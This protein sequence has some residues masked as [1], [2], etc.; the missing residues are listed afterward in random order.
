MDE[1]RIISVDVPPGSRFKGYEDVVVQD[2]VMR[3]HVVRFRRQ[4]WLTP[5]GETIIAPL[6][7]CIAGQFGPELK[8]FVSALPSG[9]NDHAPPGGAAER[10]SALS[11]PNARLFA[12]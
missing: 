11:S 4:R 7:A 2:V 9:P 6:P 5:A 8:R 1:D 10:I 3:A 12:C